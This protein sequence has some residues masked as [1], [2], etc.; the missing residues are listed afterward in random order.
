MYN[1]IS[2]R[3]SQAN[4]EHAAAS[5]QLAHSSLQ[6]SAIMKSIALSSN[7]VAIMTRRDSTDMRMIAAVTLAFLP[8]TWTAVSLH[9]LI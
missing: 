1:F 8:A 2:Q 7:E 5:R 6:E 4:I 3:D 9:S